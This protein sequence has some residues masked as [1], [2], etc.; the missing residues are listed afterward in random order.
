VRRDDE[1][2]D[3]FTSRFDRARRSVYAL[4][5][6]WSEAEEITQHAFVKVYAKW[7]RISRDN[8]DAYLRTVATR[9]FLDTRRRGRGREHAVAEPPDQPS[10]DPDGHERH[11]LLAALQYVPTKQRATLVLR[12]LHDLSIEQVAEAL[13]CS[14][15]TV[16]SQ[17]A[18][19]L[20]TLRAVYRAANTPE[21]A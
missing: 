6:N 16:K 7:P 9:L 19:G 12:F 5:G 8:P 10:Y 3:F 21:R 1:F 4:C 17:T 15:G 11:S 18:R 14:A 13:N 2:S 20:H